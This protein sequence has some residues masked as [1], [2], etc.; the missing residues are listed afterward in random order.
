MYKQ[1]NVTIGETTYLLTA[2]PGTAALGYQKQLAKVFLPAYAAA[3]KANETGE[4][5]T[6]VMLSE[7]AKSLDLVDVTFVKEL[8]IRGATI[9]GVAINF[10]T[11][12]AGNFG[13]M[14]KLLFEII[15]FNFGDV[16]QG[17][18]FGE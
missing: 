7:V 14:Y 15:K 18:G 12:F 6:A 1:E 2:I 3:A 16:F 5:A 8:I 11:H 4:N 10:D 13:N 9:N 17:L